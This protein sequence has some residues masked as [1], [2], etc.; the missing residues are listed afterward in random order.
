[1]G[2]LALLGLMGGGLG[3][4]SIMKKRG[5]DLKGKKPS[6]EQKKEL[7]KKILK[8][9]KFVRSWDTETKEGEKKRVQR[10]REVNKKMKKGFLDSIKGMF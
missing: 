2:P 4:A 1:M 6:K 3:L 9:K 7:V 10:S 5:F 8:K